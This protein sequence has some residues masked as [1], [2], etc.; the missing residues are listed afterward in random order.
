MLIYS[1]AAV[2][3][4]DALDEESGELLDTDVLLFGAGVVAD[5]RAEGD[6]VGEAAEGEGG[7]VP[8]D[9]DAAAAP[10]ET[11]RGELAWPTSGAVV[12]KPVLQARPLRPLSLLRPAVVGTSIVEA[13]ATAAA[14][15]VTATADDVAPAEPAQPLRPISLLRPSVGS[16]DAAGV[17]SDAPPGPLRPISMLRSSVADVDD[18]PCS[19]SVLYL[20]LLLRESCSQFD[21]L[22]LTSL[23]IPCGQ[24]VPASESESESERAAAPLRMRPISLLRPSV[25]VQGSHGRSITAEFTSAFASLS[26]GPPPA[27]ADAAPSEAAAVAAEDGEDAPFS[28]TKQRLQNQT[29]L[30]EQNKDGEDAPPFATSPFALLAGTAAEDAP[31][32]QTAAK[33]PPHT[34]MLPTLSGS[35]AEPAPE[36]AVEYVAA[37]VRAASP[38]PFASLAGSAAEAAPNTP[39]THV[40]PEAPSVHSESAPSSPAASPAASRA[41]SRAASPPTA[42]PTALPTA[43]PRAEALDS[44]TRA[45]SRATSIVVNSS[46]DTATVSDGEFSVFTVTFYANLAHSLTR[47]P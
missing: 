2:D 43:R 42:L 22:P 31:T 9:G 45:A 26:L 12:A 23:T 47:S 1:G 3:N 19:V 5:A 16:L 25:V 15:P 17:V 24:R 37:T 29:K 28:R 36:V 20:P 30:A 27:V 10:A 6:A 41:A 11:T 4:V 40:A 21:S 32:A 44:G 34:C 14:A 46:E 33:P 8:D 18:V 7:A 39:E 13:G 35:A 38:S